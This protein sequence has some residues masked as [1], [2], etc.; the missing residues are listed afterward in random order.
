VGEDRSSCHTLTSDK[1]A[2][3]GVSWR[4]IHMGTRVVYKDS[5]ARELSERHAMTFEGVER[6]S[7]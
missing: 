6:R 5:G 2:E 1:V 3:S 4:F 7:K